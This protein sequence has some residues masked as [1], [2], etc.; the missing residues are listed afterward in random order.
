[1]H[2]I[3]PNENLSWAVQDRDEIILATEDRIANLQQWQQQ[4]Q[5]STFVI[6]DVNDDSILNVT[7]HVTDASVLPFFG[8]IMWHKSRWKRESKN[9]GRWDDGFYI[10]RCG[11]A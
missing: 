7:P 11:I 5:Q 9:E 4:M 1:M 6:D 8:F 10:W 3:F 2:G